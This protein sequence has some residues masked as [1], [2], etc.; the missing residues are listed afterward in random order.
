M[1]RHGRWEGCRGG[2]SQCGRDRAR[3]STG[4]SVEGHGPSWPRSQTT[5]PKTDA[6]ERVP[7]KWDLPRMDA[8]ER[9][10]P[11]WTAMLCH[12]RRVRERSG[13]GLK[14]DATERVPPR[15]NRWRA[16]VPR[17]RDPKPPPRRRTRR[18]ASL[19]GGGPCSVMAAEEG[20]RGQEGRDRILFV[21][22]P[23]E[24]PFEFRPSVPVC[25]PR[26]DLS[27]QRQTKR[28]SRK[29]AKADGTSS[30]RCVE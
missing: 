24:D 14:T 28:R 12:G 4:K 8:T 30:V 6:T 9:V 15:E 11:K 16:T 1:L 22:A 17:G 27:R 10:P 21:S 29:P 2:R 18:S 25:T 3:P 5:A 7:P 13:E 23:P 20:A 26:F 19:Q